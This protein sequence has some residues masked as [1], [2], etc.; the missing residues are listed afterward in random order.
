MSDN[1]KDFLDALVADPQPM[2]DAMSGADHTKFRAQLCDAVDYALSHYNGD[3]VPS[4]VQ[5]DADRW[6]SADRGDLAE[7]IAVYLA[8]GLTVLM[9]RE[10]WANFQRAMETLKRDEVTP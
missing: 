3:R 7:H 5:F 10:N 1:D 4:G 9:E 2:R 8:A 6:R